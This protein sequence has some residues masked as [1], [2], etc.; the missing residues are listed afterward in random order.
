MKKC[1]LFWSACAL[2][3]VTTAC[4]KSSPA[5]P[6]E[7]SAAPAG[8]AVTSASVNGITLTTPQI[9]APTAGQR[10]RFAEQPLTFTVKNAVSTGA[11]PLTY[12]FQVASDANFTQIA[13]AKD[14][15][16]EG[17]GGSTSLKIDKLAGQK[18]YFVRVRA[19]SGSSAGPFGTA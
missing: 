6:T 1:L 9:T 18:D 11:T 16:A 2:L 3:V 13:Y 14:G 15:V 8:E 10:Y 17:S 19:N 7:T 12:T 5:R 4:T